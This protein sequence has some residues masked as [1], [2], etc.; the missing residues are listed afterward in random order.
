[1]SRNKNRI[2]VPQETNK[3]ELP[4][5]PPK[6][7]NDNPFG[8]SF[9]VPTEIVTLPSGG[10]LY[11]ENSA[12]KGLKE[13]EVKSMT[14]AE[15]DIMINDSFI[16]KGVVF[17]RLI[18]SIMITPGIKS[19]EL[20]DCDKLAILMS[21]RKTGYGD[22]ISFSVS[23]GACNHDYDID[24][25]LTQML[26]RSEENPY[27]PRSGE[28][29]EY[30]EDSNTYSF[31]ITSVDIDANIKLL[32]RSE[33]KDLMA[34]REQKKRLGLPFNE[35]IEF[36]RAVL[37][38]A[39]GITDRTSLNK[40]AEILPASAARRIRYV[41]NVNLPKIDTSQEVTCPAC[42]QEETKEVPFSLGWFWS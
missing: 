31:N 13:V 30:L 3:N 24:A 11:P 38:S 16:Q 35:T 32:T 10:H 27:E 29:W 22:A 34:S 2:T 41:H 39:N 37:V 14:A 9:V 7:R 4:E 25:S 8:L 12:L 19:E 17:D 15:E 6:Q 28:G 5:T 21:A 23:C 20:Q 1:M 42:G 33:V 36:L 26:E 18:D 40:L